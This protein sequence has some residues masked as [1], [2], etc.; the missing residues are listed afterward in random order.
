VE[1]HHLTEELTA[2]EIANLWTAYQEDTLNICGISFFLT[3]VDDPQI[4]ALLEQSLSLAKKRQEREIHFFQEA[5]YPI[6]QGF[7]DKDV[8]F[9]APRLFS[10]KLYLEYILD[11]SNLS[12]I[13][14]GSALALAVRPD[15]INFYTENLHDIESLHKEAK[16]LK[17]EKGFLIRAP[18]IPKPDQIHFVKKDSFLSGWL[19]DRRPLLGTEI[20]NLVYNFERNAL[21]QAIITGFSQVVESD[22]AIR[23]FEKGRDISGKHHEIFSNILRENYLSAGILLTPEV[24]DSTVSPFSDK[25]MMNFVTILITSGISQYGMAMAESPRHD[26]AAQYTKLMAEIGKYANEGANILIDHGWM[27]QPPIAADRKDL[28]KR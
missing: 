28:A 9:D 15:L 8:N 21:G 14:Y 18:N 11:M 27:E 7:S 23:F 1:Q 5:N 20:A 17:R 16:E 19:G 10:D 3:H 24:T 22:D 13:T 26:L 4:R 2:P 6:P 12:I 25:L